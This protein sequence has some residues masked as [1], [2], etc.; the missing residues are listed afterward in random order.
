MGVL[1][2]TVVK[3]VASTAATKL[4]G[5][6]PG[7]VNTAVGK[8]V[9]I[10]I[11]GVRGVPGAKRVAAKALV[12]RR[13]VKPAIESVVRAHVRIATISGAVTNIGGIVSEIVGTPANLTGIIVIQLRMVACVAHLHGYDIDDPRVRTAITMCLL[14]EEELARQIAD[15]RLPSTPT[16]VATASIHDKALASQVIDQVLRHLLI[17][18]HGLLGLFARSVPILGGGLTGLDDWTATKRVAR[19]ARIHF[20]P[21]R[22]IAGV[23]MV[24][25]PAGSDSNPSLDAE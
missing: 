9:D 23:T 22:P 1:R 21:R 17:P 13:A 16:A 3:A 6:V 15:G 7:P 4:P 14:G 25:L 5:V 12:R 24:R 8:L 11:D 19:C 20:I 18:G 10:A 2:S